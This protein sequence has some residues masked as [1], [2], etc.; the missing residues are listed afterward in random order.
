MQEMGRGLASRILH[1][2]Q[3]ET[4]VQGNTAFLDFQDDVWVQI[5][6]ALLG[7]R[8]LVL[9]PFVAL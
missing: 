8:F 2:K 3:A 7:T 9:L 4:T 6:T 5:P 1:S